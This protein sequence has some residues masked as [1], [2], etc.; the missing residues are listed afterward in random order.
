MNRWLYLPK[1]KLDASPE[2]LK[3]DYVVLAPNPYRVNKKGVV[4]TTP[5][6][7]VSLALWDGESF[8]NPESFAKIETSFY[9]KLPKY[10]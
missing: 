5:P 9:I 8:R 3:A 2:A 7:T 6:Y 1:D 10:C 4:N